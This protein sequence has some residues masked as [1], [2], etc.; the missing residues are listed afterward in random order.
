MPK[1]SDTRTTRRTTLN[2]DRVLDAGVALADAEGINALTMR[3]LAGELDVEAMSLYN[4]VNNKDDLLDGMLDRVVGEI[5]LP[6]GGPDWR[7][8]ARRRAISAH[9]ILMRHPWAA[10]MW[11]S[12]LNPGPARMRYVDTSLRNLREAG[13]SSGLLD[14][15]FHTIEN[16]IVGHAL[17]ALGFPLESD[18][19]EEASEQF[20]RSFPVKEYPDLAAH[21]RHHMEHPGEGDEFEFGLELI[22]DGV[23]RI[24]PAPGAPSPGA[25]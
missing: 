21:V 22:L 2:R 13:F 14:R 11:V 7:H 3:R 23:E 6:E 8:R 4:H 16:H 10:A 25:K 12:R 18:E 1:A 15:T 19:M 24:G 20:L 9:A 17:Q 5:E